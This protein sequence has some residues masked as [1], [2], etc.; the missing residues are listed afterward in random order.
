M[1]SHAEIVREFASRKGIS[2]RGL[3]LQ[4]DNS[5]KSDEF[6]SANRMDYREQLDFPFSARKKITVEFNLVKPYVNAVAGFMVQNRRMAKYVARVPQRQEQDRFSKDANAI[7]D[8]IRKNTRADQVESIQNKQML[9]KGYGAVETAMTYGDG[10]ATR[11]PNGEVL[12]GDVTDDV[13]WDPMAR[14]QNLL[15]SRWCFYR[16]SYALEDAKK[17]FNDSDE[18][19]FDVADD[20]SETGFQYDPY[21]YPYD[22]SKYETTIDSVYEWDNQHENSVWVYFYQWYE[23]ETF[24]RADNPLA[25]IQNPMV[26]KMAL[27]KMQA[28]AEELTDDSMF[29][30]DPMAEVLTF[31]GETK[32]KLEDIFE[33]L[34]KCYP[35]SRKAYYTGILSGKK[36]FKAYRSQS[37][38]G[39]T[40]KFKT[41]DWDNVNKIWVGMVNSMMDPVKYY[42]KSLTELMYL[43]ANNSKGGWFVESDAIEDIRDFEAMV[44]KTDGVVEVQPGALANGKIKEKKTPF[45]PSGY[46]NI[47]SIAGQALPMTTGLDPAFLGSSENKLE[48]AM[49]QRQRVRQVVSTLACYFDA[50]GAYQE[51]HARLMLDLM[52]VYAENNKGGIIRIVGEQG[53]QEFLRISQD[54]FA[55]EYDV[56]I[57]EAPQTPEDREQQAQVLIAMGDKLMAVGNP[58]GAVVYAA[59]VEMLPLESEAKN[60]VLQSLTPPDDPRIAQLQQQIQ[61]LTSQFSQAQLMDL[62]ETANKK[63]AEAELTTAKIQQTAADIAKTSEEIEHISIENQLMPHVELSKISV[64]A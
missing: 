29:K 25:S 41:G 33:D 7:S 46:D 11:D 59:A 5:A 44:N 30:F 17:L 43:I 48:T 47:L 21:I 55:V 2:N 1:K 13:G 36:V 26:M 60:K 51:E 35:Y 62:T 8:Y 49:L 40:V 53:E 57:M 56:D 31:D 32:E 28:I 63:R 50:I 64:S 16:K 9:I 22:K 61:Q 39:F 20:R 12:M 15:D 34:L 6:Y 27:T 37:Q 14:M 18:D 23:V 3:A 4:K 54:A 52:K 58:A 19:D 42:N 38:Q 10:Y 24:Y 45:S